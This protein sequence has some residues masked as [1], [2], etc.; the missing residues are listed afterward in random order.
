MIQSKAKAT[1]TVK[2]TGSTSAGSGLAGG[3]NMMADFMKAQ[4]A[5]KDLIE[6][7]TTIGGDGGNPEEFVIECK[8][9]GHN[10]QTTSTIADNGGTQ[11]EKKTE[12]IVSSTKITASSTSTTKTTGTGD[13]RTAP[14]VSQKGAISKGTV[15]KGTTTKGTSSTG[16]AP[17][18]KPLTGPSTMKS[19]TTSKKADNV[20]FGPQTIPQLTWDDFSGKPVPNSWLAYT[21]YFVRYT[22]KTVTTNGKTSLQAIKAWCVL[23]NKTSWVVWRNQELLEH[24]IG[25]YHIGWISAL[26]FK[27]K[28]L[29]AKLPTEGTAQEIAR[30]Y[31]ET[32]KEFRPWQIQYDEET[33]HYCNKEGQARWNAKIKKLLDEL[34]PYL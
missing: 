7:F 1:T 11:E 4:N 23:N 6:T 2:K 25:H 34:K 18:K 19:P 31:K 24:E 16:I 9:V 29:E 32:L 3:F 28:V 20:D 30:I 17:V 14:S 22:F 5:M 33:E 15:S 12:S 27:K 10:H 21:T 13:K 8:N 26:T